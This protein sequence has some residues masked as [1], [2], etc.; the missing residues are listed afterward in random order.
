MQAILPNTLFTVLI[1]VALVAAGGLAIP[2]I[3]RF[4]RLIT[5]RSKLDSLETGPVQHL[6]RAI[7]TQSLPV[8][9]MDKDGAFTWGNQAFLNLA[10]ELHVTEDALADI[11]NQISPADLP[12]NIDDQKLLYSGSVT[13]F[14]GGKIGIA[15]PGK[16]LVDS[17][18]SLNRLME[19]LSVTFANLPVGLAI[20]DKDDCISQF[21]PALTQVLGLDPTWLARRPTFK[22]VLEKLREARRLP[23][24]R[25]FLS[26]R[27][28]LTR[29][30]EVEDGN[31]YSDLWYLADGTV[32]QVS[33]RAHKQGART[34]LFEDITARVTL[35][36]QH[37]AE[38]S[39]NQAVLDQIS[40]GVMVLNTAGN[41][42]FANTVCDRLLDID[43]ATT[44][45]NVQLSLFENRFPLNNHEF[46]AELRNY[47]SA[48]ENRTHW[49]SR[50]WTDRYVPVD[51][52]P[53]PDGS[54]L[55]LFSARKEVR[56]P[57]ELVETDQAKR[58]QSA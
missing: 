14:E 52:F 47:L 54:T 49:R 31:S 32:L 58:S 30:S 48:T 20:F 55:L 25:D 12:H 2:L 1:W 38:T 8:W 43:T 50:V 3:K 39:L 44:V 33:G 27:R 16:D 19:T 45:E 7:T 56:Q 5:R 57:V 17:R 6:S 37:F 36:R 46:W 11:L 23:H 29:M 41:L 26:W 9:M 28:L 34:Y 22:S 24:Q 10:Q 35:E 53:M 21:N 4:Q 42:V 15:L 18:N 13:E 51:I 40:D